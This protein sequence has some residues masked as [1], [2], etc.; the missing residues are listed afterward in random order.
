M[1]TQKLSLDAKARE[2]LEK[3]AAS[4]AGR[5]AE[6]LYGGHENT[7]R[8]T[9]L[10]LRADTE[11]AEHDSPGKATLLILHGRVTLRSGEDSWEGTT[12]DLLTIPPARHS[13]HA[14]EDAAVLLTVAKHE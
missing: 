9:L 6:T 5:S 13:L 10:A 12:G 3:A 7:V 11:L 4:S 1:T 14:L 2:H 8:Q